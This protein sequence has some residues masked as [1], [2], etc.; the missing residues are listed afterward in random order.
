MAKYPL[1]ST[2]ISVGVDEPAD[3]RVIIAALEVVEAGLGVVIIAAVAQGVDVGDAGGISEDFRTAVVHCAVAPCIIV[4]ER[5]HSA[6]RIK[7]GRHVTLCVDKVIVQL[8]R[9]PVLIDHREGL[10]AVVID[11][12]KS[13]V[14]APSLP[15]DLAGERRVGIG[16]ITDLLAAADTSHVIG[17]LHGLAAHD[18]L[19]ELTPLRPV[20]MVVTAVVVRDRVAGGREVARLR[21]PLIQD[22]LGR[23]IRRHAR[24]QVRPRGIRVA[25][26]LDKR[27]AAR[28]AL[29][30]APDVA[31]R[32]VGA[33]AQRDAA[34][35]DDDLWLCA[36]GCTH[37]SD[38]LSIFYLSIGGVFTFA[39]FTMRSTTGKITV[40]ING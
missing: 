29:C 3:G 10:A 11:E 23:A 17:V 8:R 15:H 35:N 40:N 25:E 21:L 16:R 24:K 38:Y 28:I 27:S 26:G 1:T 12:L 19:C 31:R 9:R 18:G 7:D 32:I 2:E 5:D 14:I 6:R 36:D 34:G 20:E 13:V 30:N 4:V 37:H 22:V 39:Q 33:A